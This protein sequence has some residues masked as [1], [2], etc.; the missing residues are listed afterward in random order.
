M[1]QVA[2]GSPPWKNPHPHSLCLLPEK[3]MGLGG[4]LKATKPAPGPAA[5]QALGE[6]GMI[7]SWDH[8]FPQEPAF[9]GQIRSRE[10]CSPCIPSLLCSELMGYFLYIYIFWQYFMQG[11]ASPPFCTAMTVPEVEYPC[12]AMALPPQK[13]PHQPGTAKCNISN[14]YMIL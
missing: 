10:R 5:L 6:V 14:T 4:I 3:Q 13:A 1:W 9:S 7:R 11:T 2:P 12:L 8:L